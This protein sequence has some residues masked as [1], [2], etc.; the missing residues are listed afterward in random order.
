MI[1]LLEDDPVQAG[2]EDLD[3]R[4]VELL[5]ENIRT[6]V[7]CILNEG[8]SPPQLPRDDDLRG[9]EIH[10]VPV[11]NVLTIIFE[12]TVIQGKASV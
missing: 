4:L 8:R 9:L 11:L 5:D 6:Q 3:G 7:V 1:L 10:Q 2:A 12:N